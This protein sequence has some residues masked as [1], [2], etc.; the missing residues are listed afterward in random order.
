MTSDP[1]TVEALPGERDDDAFLAAFFDCT[2]PAEEFHHRD[3]VRLTWLALRRWG[4]ED[5]TARVLDGIRRYAAAQGAAQK[6][7]A[8]LTRRW[9]A[10]VAEALRGA[11]PHEPFGAFLARHPRL[12]DKDSDAPGPAAG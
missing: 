3:H 7:D 8:P 2:L 6:F 1:A 10:R 5:G 9:A 11:P 12:L 4:A